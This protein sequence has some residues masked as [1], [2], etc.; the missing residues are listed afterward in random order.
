MIEYLVRGIVT[1][2]SR[3]ASPRMTILFPSIR[4]RR[5]SG[6]RLAN[7]RKYE[8]I[9]RDRTKHEQRNAWKAK[10]PR[11]PGWLSVIGH[12]GKQRRSAT[13]GDEQRQAATSSDESVA[14]LP[15][16]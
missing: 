10:S 1:G 2:F 6:N 7:L 15:L 8:T 14:F 4:S 11:F 13:I 5:G 3:R 16:I 9:G 12:P